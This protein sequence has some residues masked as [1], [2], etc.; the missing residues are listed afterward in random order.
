LAW[1]KNVKSTSGA[2]IGVRKERGWACLAK[3][4]YTALKKVKMVEKKGKGPVE[5]KFKKR[6]RASERS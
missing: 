2:W 6:N 3:V 1:G 5:K 4:R